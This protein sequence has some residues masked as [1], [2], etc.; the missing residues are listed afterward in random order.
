[1]ADL[2]DL[3]DLRPPKISVNSCC[4]DPQTAQWPA[5]IM[6]WM[7]LPEGVAVLVTIHVLPQF[8]RQGHGQRL[9]ERFVSDA[10]AGGSST[11]T[12]GVHRNNPG[13]ELYELAGFERTHADSE[14]LYYAM[15]V[16]ASSSAQRSRSLPGTTYAQTDCAGQR[17]CLALKGFPS[18]RRRRLLDDPAVAVR[19]A[20]IGEG[21]SAHVLDLAD[22]RS[23]L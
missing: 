18:V 10:S 5:G 8:R 23:A 20:E 17:P 9:L 2:E 4:D 14:Y 21:D 15:A 6:L 16:L 13:R 11:L 1:M 19:V 3:V 22:L 12:W 7:P